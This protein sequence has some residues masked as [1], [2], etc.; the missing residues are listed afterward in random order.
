MKVT[1]DALRAARSLFRSCQVDGVLD[2]DK[3]RKV[4][5]LVAERKPR[6]YLGILSALGRLVRLEQERC[7]A[8]IVSAG[9]LGEEEKKQLI[10][11]LAKSHGSEMSV[12]FRE[13]PLLLGGLRVK[14]GSDVWDGTVRARL[15]AFRA[16][17]SS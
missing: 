4:V 7:H 8:E 2:H 9:P 14:V 16:R 15:D 12:A 17:L 13:D 6:R 3:V 5:A 11:G 10:D 1:K